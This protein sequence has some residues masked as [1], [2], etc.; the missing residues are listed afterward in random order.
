[1]FPFINFSAKGSSGNFQ[2]KNFPKYLGEGRQGCHQISFSFTSRSWNLS[3]FV[4]KKHLLRFIIL[5]LCRA[6]DPE[7]GFQSVRRKELGVSLHIVICK[8][9]INQCPLIQIITWEIHACTALVR[10]TSWTD[11]Y[12]C[13]L[14]PGWHSCPM[15]TASGALPAPPQSLDQ[16]HRDSSIRGHEHRDGPRT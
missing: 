10:S 9:R 8:M 3:H 13:C 5:L 11:V 2:T 15:S 4:S 12:W 1:M 14:A 7:L 16:G 6:L